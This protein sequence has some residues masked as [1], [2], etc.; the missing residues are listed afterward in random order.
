[1][2]APAITY[3]NPGIEPE[4]KIESYLMYLLI[5]LAARGVFLTHT[6]HLTDA[7]LYDRVADLSTMSQEQGLA[8]VRG[9]V[10]V[11][12]CIDPR[13]DMG[14]Y[15]AIYASDDVRRSWFRLWPEDTLPNPR[16][17]VANRDVL[18]R[19]LRHTYERPNA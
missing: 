15:L 3:Q 11:I 5:Q 16:P 18:L 9:G 4:S 17:R 14:T 12:S 8:V 19:A 1:M 10:S 2:H 7:E 6:D 13:T